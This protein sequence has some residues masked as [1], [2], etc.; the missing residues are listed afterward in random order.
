MSQ[1]F[2]EH[3]SNAYSHH[4]EKYVSVLEPVL[5]PMAEE[6]TRLA[7]LSGWQ[8]A[9]D[10]ATGTGLIARAL[11]RLD[12][13]VI[14]VDF[15]PGILRIADTQSKRDIQFVSGD[16]HKLPFKDQCFDLVTCGVSLSHFLDVT[17]ALGEVLRLLRPGGRFITSAWG[18][19]GEN[20]SKEAAVEVRQKFLEERQVTF[21]GLFSEDL[22]A[23]TERGSETLERAGFGDVQVTTSPISGEYTSHEDAIETALAWPITR[24]RIAQLPDAD[25]A[26]LRE[27]TAA[28]IR[29]V[30]D[31]RWRTEVHYYEAVRSRV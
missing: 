2:G 12:G 17:A 30:E 27:E 16:A 20:L 29:Q 10:L 26:R 21:G 23:D 9:L 6:I 4:S 25:Q 5:A 8:S 14:G 24:Y 31:L 15:S 22:W 28:A 1:G 3:I 18:S 11:A 7:G 13:F 19:G